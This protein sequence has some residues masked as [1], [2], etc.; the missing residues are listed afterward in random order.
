L[1]E[2]LL[3]VSCNAL[4]VLTAEQELEIG[5]RRLLRL[6][7]GPVHQLARLRERL[8]L[9]WSLFVRRL[10]VEGEQTLNL[11][12][13]RFGEALVGFVEQLDALFES[14]LE[15]ARLFWLALCRLLIRFHNYYN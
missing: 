8:L 1:I 2:C 11:E 15:V 5:V 6:R 4:L 3:Q 12:V 7:R 14:H 10:C 9:L 13:R